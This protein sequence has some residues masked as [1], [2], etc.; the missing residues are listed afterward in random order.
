MRDHRSETIVIAQS[1]LFDSYRVVLVDDRDNPNFDHSPDSSPRM[2]ILLPVIE[3]DLGEE[4]LTYG[5][6][7]GRK[8]SRVSLHQP[9]LS[10]RR[11]DLKAHN[12]RWTLLKADR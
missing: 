2:E 1:K 5:P 11:R 6:S 12:V 3:C 7:T 10:D 9:H 4:N 8:L